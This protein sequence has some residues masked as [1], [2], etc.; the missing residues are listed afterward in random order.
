MAS[1]SVETLRIYYCRQCRLVF[2]FLSDIDYHRRST[3][4]G[5]IVSIDV[6]EGEREFD[7]NY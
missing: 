1:K 3:A 6:P 2:F 7:I 4:H 5:D